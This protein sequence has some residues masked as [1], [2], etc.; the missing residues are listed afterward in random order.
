[1]TDQEAHAARTHTPASNRRKEA[2]EGVVEVPGYKRRRQPIPAQPLPA[3]G[4]PRL[5]SFA[6]ASYGPPPVEK[7]ADVPVAQGADYDV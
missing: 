5:R 4:T 2:R 6:K 3:A 7:G 1:M